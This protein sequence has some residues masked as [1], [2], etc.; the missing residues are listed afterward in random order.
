MSSEDIESLGWKEWGAARN[1]GTL[2]YGW[3]DG[4]TVLHYNG[5]N[6]IYKKDNLKMLD[7]I[8]IKRIVKKDLTFDLLYR[9]SCYT[10]EELATLMES[11]KIK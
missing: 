8:E 1:G 11:L 3:K 4:L 9:G 2:I 6:F 7:I 10:R 5:D